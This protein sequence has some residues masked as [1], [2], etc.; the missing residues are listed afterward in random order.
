MVGERFS[1]AL[2]GEI[3]TKEALEN[4]QWV[5]GRVIERARRVR[6]E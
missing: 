2:A 4:A 6:D 1:K 5:T 3:S